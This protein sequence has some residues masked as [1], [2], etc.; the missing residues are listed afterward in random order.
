MVFGVCVLLL[1]IRS[2]FFL[3]NDHQQNRPNSNQTINM[4]SGMFNSCKHETWIWDLVFICVYTHTYKVHF[5]YQTTFF[6][7]YFSLFFCTCKIKSLARF[8]PSHSFYHFK[9]FDLVVIF[10]EL[11]TA[12][13][14]SFLCTIFIQ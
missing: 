6:F 4:S 8:F 9:H 11:L 5:S 7:K 3:P 10:S 14:S 12:T 2:R 13:F 1:R